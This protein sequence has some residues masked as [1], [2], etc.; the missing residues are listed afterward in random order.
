MVVDRRV[1]GE[2]LGAR[3]LNRALLA[4]QML[5]ARGPLGAAEAI[6]RLVGMQAQADRRRRVG[7]GGADHED[8]ARVAAPPY[9]N[10]LFSFSTARLLEPS[11]SSAWNT[12]FT[13]IVEPLGGGAEISLITVRVPVPSFTW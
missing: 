2:V 13:P 11:V 9:W 7:A 5:L 1:S 4:R 12:P 3:A 6:E 8:P 10:R